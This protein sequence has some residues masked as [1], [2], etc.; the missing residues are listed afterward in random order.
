MPNETYLGVP[1]EMAGEVEVPRELA[2]GDRVFTEKE[3][4]AI[5][6]NVVS[7]ETASLRDANTALEVQVAT[8]TAEKAE[9]ETARAE[10][11]QREKAA[12]DKLAERDA[13]IEKAAELKTLAETRMATM[14][15]V[16]KHLPAEYFTA[17]KAEAW[18]KLDEDSFAS[19]SDAIA[20]TAPA[21]GTREVASTT[22]IVGAPA[23]DKKPVPDARALVRGIA[24]QN[25]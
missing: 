10:A 14:R 6:A 21:G 9:A 16:A 5:M 15:E 25:S 1:R 11:E 4:L 12:T 23:G 3:H 20:A 13:E 17:E 2:E 18:A 24:G 19:L 8:L 22:I 7:T